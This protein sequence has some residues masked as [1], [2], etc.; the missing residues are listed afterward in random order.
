M[1]V[2]IL[3][4]GSC[5]T[6]R[7]GWWRGRSWWVVSSE[8]ITATPSAMPTWRKVVFAPLATPELCP[9]I[10]DSTT[11]VSCAPAKPM[12]IPHRA[13]PGMSCH[14]VVWSEITTGSTAPGAYALIPNRTTIV[15]P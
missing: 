6:V 7:S 9:G 2:R 8:P 3:L 5:S 13:R 14:A 1:P 15:G 4:A 12:P 10:S 11:L